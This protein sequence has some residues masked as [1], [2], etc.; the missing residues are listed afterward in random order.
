MIKGQVSETYV[1]FICY[2]VQYISSIAAR[3]HLSTIGVIYG[4]YGGYAYPPEFRRPGTVPPQKN[5][6]KSKNHISRYTSISLALS[7]TLDLS[8]PAS[9]EHK[10]YHAHAKAAAL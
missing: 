5:C 8:K 1:L 4:E 9:K 10:K 6:K 2:T 3:K 7:E